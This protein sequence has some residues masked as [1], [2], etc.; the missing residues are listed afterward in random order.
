MR[1]AM[2]VIQEEFKD[3]GLVNFIANNLIYDEKDSKYQYVKW[4]CNL[5][6]ILKNIDSLLSFPESKEIG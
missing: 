4:G 2:K 1:N 5:E 6:S 3:Q